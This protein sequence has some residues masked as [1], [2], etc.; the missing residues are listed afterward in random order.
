MTGPDRLDVHMPEM[1]RATFRWWCISTA[2]QAG[3]DTRA[4]EL[5]DRDHHTLIAGIN[6]ADDQ[7]DSE[8]AAFIGV[9]GPRPAPRRAAIRALKRVRRGAGPG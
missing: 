8:V 9:A 2:A 3:T 7:I 1:A 6:D 4:L 5:L